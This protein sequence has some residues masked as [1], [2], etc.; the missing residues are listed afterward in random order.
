MAQKLAVH[1]YWMWRHCRNHGQFQKLGS[2][3]GGP[4]HPDG[5]QSITD[6]MIGHPGPCGA[7]SSN[8]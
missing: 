6:V 7:G 3:A 4:G 2:H 1:L 8:Q 5:E